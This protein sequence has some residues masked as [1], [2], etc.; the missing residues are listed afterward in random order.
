MLLTLNHIC[1]NIGFQNTYMERFLCKIR[2]ELIAHW[3]GATLHPF[4]ITIKCPKVMK[5]NKT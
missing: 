4:L 1:P 3:L 2:V 5:Q